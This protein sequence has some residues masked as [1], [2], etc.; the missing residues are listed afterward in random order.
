M[1]GFIE[2]SIGS[3][4]GAIEQALFTQDYVR[5]QGLL[6][7]IDPRI[8]LLSALLILVSLSFAKN[9]PI[10]IFVYLLLIFLAILSLVPLQFFLKRVWLFLPIFTGVI[11]LPVLFITPGD[12]IFRLVYLP[13][14][15][16]F[17]SITG[18]GLQLAATILFRVAV[19][20]SVVILLILTTR[21]QNLLRAAR[22]IKIPAVFIV[23]LSM[24]YRYIFL[25][26]YTADNMLLSRK[27]RLTGKISGEENRN[28]VGSAVGTLFGKSFKLS[29]DVFMAMQSRGFSGEVRLLD[30]FSLKYSDVLF[31][32]V[33]IILSVGIF[34]FGR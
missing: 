20:V 22:I 18:T 3:I 23:I 9:L 11:I 21:W 25:L 16:L 4:N 15:N 30:D 26:L 12:V 28:W 2:K 19:M 31:L 34:Y 8:K 1:S 32:V 5:R 7:G 13:K 24:T 27:S 33:C 29:E 10:I 6:Q 17:L 14:L